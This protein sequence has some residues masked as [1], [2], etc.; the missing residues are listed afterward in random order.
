MTVHCDLLLQKVNKLIQ[1]K[2]L[3]YTAKM[4]FIIKIKI[5]VTLQFLKKTKVV[6][7]KWL[8]KEIENEDIVL[9]KN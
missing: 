8:L 3:L 7:K 9:K 2:L 5:R 4:L 1:K 6:I